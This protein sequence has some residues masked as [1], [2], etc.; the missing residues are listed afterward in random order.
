VEYPV[1]Q[2]GNFASCDI[3]GSWYQHGLFVYCKDCLYKFCRCCNG[4]W[5]QCT[6]ALTG[7]ESPSC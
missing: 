3:H 7:Y 6:D 5:T 2:N 4:V 1:D